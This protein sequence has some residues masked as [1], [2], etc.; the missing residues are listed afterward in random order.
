VLGRIKEDRSWQWAAYGKHPT[1]KDYFKVCYEFPS[2]RGFSGWM[3]KGFQI[4]CSRRGKREG[5][6]A[7]RFWGREGLKGKILCG[8]MRDSSDSL[9][10][11]YPLLIIGAGPMEEWENN[12]DLLPYACENS[13]GEMELLALS[14]FA[15]IRGVE[16]GVRNIRP[17][18]PDWSG[19][20]SRREQFQMVAHG[21]L[22]TLAKNT[23]LQPAS[24]QGYINLDRKGEISFS[25][26]IG[27]YHFLLKSRDSNPPHII[28]LGGNGDGRYL[29]YFRR[30]LVSSDFINLWT[31]GS[32]VP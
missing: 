7:W 31:I 20:V 16:A 12:W 4:L 1:V 15:D 11:P 17:P 2:L 10:R 8:T 9:G 29:V 22:K 25:E 3:E 13:W 23:L 21:D 19:F 5:G 27:L 14:R 32:E 28:F 6:S 26:T 18:A 30:S 24:K